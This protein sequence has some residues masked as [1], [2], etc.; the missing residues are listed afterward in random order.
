MMKKTAWTLAGFSLTQLAI[1][2]GAVALPLAAQ[3]QAQAP[4]PNI[5]ETLPP[6]AGRKN[7]AQDLVER[8]LSRH[9]E[10][11]EL[12]IHA[13]PPGSAASVIVAAKNP[14]RVGKAS[15]TDDLAVLKTGTPRVEINQKGNNNV[16]VAVQLQD[17]TK[18]PVGVVEMTFPYV[19]GTDEE[20]LIKQA[21]DLADELRRRIAHGAEDLVTPAQY[22]TRVKPDTYAQY[23][24]DDA[25]TKQPGVLVLVLHTRDASGGYPIVGSSIGRIGKAADAS[26]LAVISSGKTVH[27]ASA[28]GTRIEVKT[29]I[30]DSAGNVV[31]EVVAVYPR[32]LAAG[33][34]LAS[35]TEKIRD[36]LS[37]KIASASNLFGPYPTT[38]VAQGVQTDYDKQELGNQQ[39]LPMTKAVTSGDKLEQA[40]QE[41]YSEAIKGVAGVA[42]TNSKGSPNDAIAIRGIKLNLFS[43]YRL[44]G[45]APAAGG[46]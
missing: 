44:N 42:S 14:G 25:L 31:G 37:A 40:S 27:A 46:V 16:E 35:Q 8:T 1:A 6:I 28:D 45:G 41:G 19:A 21:R 11:I 17:V 39:S 34:V 2:A 18:Q 30:R 36:S 12:D 29:P 38:Q 22:D 32:G 24:V 7:Y 4:R 9:P 5:E 20:A 10:L 13:T 3:A 15:D 23:L 43:N 33:E 26:D